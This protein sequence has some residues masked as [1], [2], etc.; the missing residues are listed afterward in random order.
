MQKVLVTV[1]QAS[2]G[3]YWC[4]T[5]SDVYGCGLNGAG[6]TVKA[7]KDDLMVCL[8]D[9]KEEFLEEG[10]ELY[11]VEFEYKY[12]LQ[13]FF[14][15]FSFLNVSE[16]AK[17]AGINPSLMRQYTSGVKNAGEKTYS[18]LS[19]CMA[20]ITRELQAASFR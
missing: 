2:D 15:Y 8:E 14:D 17:R 7:A 1:S 20:T 13:S 3:S 12:D 4:H 16:I 19:A 5:E 9:A 10:G 18:R 6:A 11:D